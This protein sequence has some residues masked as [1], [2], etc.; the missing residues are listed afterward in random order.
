MK[1][2][3]KE[4]VIT[5]LKKCAKE[6]VIIS[7]DAPIPI[8]KDLERHC[9]VVN[10]EM[11]YEVILAFIRNGGDW[12]IFVESD[13]KHEEAHNLVEK[14]IKNVDWT[15]LMALSPIFRKNIS[16]IVE[17]YYI[18]NILLKDYFNKK[19]TAMQ[20]MLNEIL[21]TAISSTKMWKKLGFVHQVH[22]DLMDLSLNI[23]RGLIDI[24]RLDFPIEE[25]NFITRTVKALKKIK[26]P[27]DMQRACEEIRDITIDWLKKVGYI[28][29]REHR[30]HTMSYRYITWRKIIFATCLGLSPVIPILIWLILQRWSK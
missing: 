30:F 24:N 21:D 17:D 14:Y 1:I 12:R 22:T 13:V 5:F 9:I 11:Y 16:D 19:Y 3:S 29:E 23:A 2:P 28:I 20:R 6:K 27:E 18:D 4:E 8:G 7:K 26:R 25:M 15:K 10:P